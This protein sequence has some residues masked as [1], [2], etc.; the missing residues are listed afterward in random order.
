MIIFGAFTTVI[1]EITDVLTIRLNAARRAVL[2][3]AQT[4]FI[5]LA[6]AVS[7]LVGSVDPTEA[8]YLDKPVEFDPLGPGVLAYAIHHDRPHSFLVQRL[9]ANCVV[10]IVG[11]AKVAPCGI[12]P[13]ELG[14]GASGAGEMAD[15]ITIRRN[16]LAVNP[17]QF[18]DG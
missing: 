6:C 16:A 1:A 3:T 10:T 7:T 13:V 18:G 17:D 2:W 8:V 14:T 12:N 4:G 11:T 15:G 5:P 9:S